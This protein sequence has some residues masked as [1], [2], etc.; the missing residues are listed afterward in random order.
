MVGIISGLETLSGTKVLISP[1]LPA[2]EDAAGYKGVTGWVEF[3]GLATWGEWGDEESDVPVKFLG[4]G[5]IL[6][7]NGLKDGG[8]VEFTVHYVDDDPASDLVKA[9]EGSRTQFSVKKMYASGDSEF[10]YGMFTSP[11]YA[12]EDGD[13]VRGYRGRFRSNGK[14][15][16]ATAEELAA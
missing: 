12:A 13:N 11:K 14:V 7:L 9:N 10:S 16:A 8:E 2:S 15:V 4:T 3:T 6:H 1:N 5:R